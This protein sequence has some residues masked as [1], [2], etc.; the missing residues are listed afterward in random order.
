[1]YWG[2]QRMQFLILATELSAAGFIAN[3][4]LNSI[5]FPVS[6]LGANWGV[7]RFNNQGFMM[8][9]GAT[10][11]TSLGAF[12][13]GLTIVVAASNFTPVVGYNNIHT[14]SSPFVWD[15]SSNIIIE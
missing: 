6:S 1:M 2:G 5:Q 10:T 4:P 13:T 7:T 14:F 11:L 8:N 3:S 9:V 12:Q 15:G